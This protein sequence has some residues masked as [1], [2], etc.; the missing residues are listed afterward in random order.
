[1][2]DHFSLHNCSLWDLGAEV[3]AR[4]FVMGE[5]WFR[6]DVCWVKFGQDMMC[7]GWRWSLAKWL[8]VMGEVWSREFVKN[9]G[10]EMICDVW[11]REFVKKFG[12]EMICDGWSL[13]KRSSVRGEVWSRDHLWWVKFGPDSWD[14]E[15]QNP[16]SKGSEFADAS[17]RIEHKEQP[18]RIYYSKI[19]SRKVQQPTYSKSLVLS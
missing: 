6:D 19:L 1:M 3:W 17:Q 2:R 5:V 12:L 4:W 13:V 18:N 15:C 8:S 7:E 9:S 11:S 14:R 10:Q 16:P